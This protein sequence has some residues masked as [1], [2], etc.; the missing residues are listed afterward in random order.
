MVI[1]NLLQAI[2]TFRL[3]EQ[4]EWFGH[5]HPHSRATAGLARCFAARYSDRIRGATLDEIECGAH[6]HDIGKYLVSKEIL[7]KPGSLD[8]EEQA[9]MF[10]HPIYGAQILNNLS[11]VT[12]NII[13]IVRNH[14]E[15]WDGTGYPEGISGCRISFATRI[16]TI[17]DVYTSLRAK[18]PYKG[19]LTRDET[20]IEL[21]KM[22]ANEL[23]PNLVND[24][25]K[26]SKNQKRKVYCA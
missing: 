12:A 5:I 15:K 16:V 8:K 14:H 1:K 18:R 9:A 22:A 11:C 6:L 19:M 4:P 21:E 10:F 17:V 23:D 7:F 20:Y 26:Y 2:G 24:F 3:K 25:L 13:Q